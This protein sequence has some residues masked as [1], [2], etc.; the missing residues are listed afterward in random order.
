MNGLIGITTAVAVLLCVGVDQGANLVQ[1]VPLIL[2]R[3]GARKNRPDG[4]QKLS[5][6]RKIAAACRDFILELKPGSKTN[7]IFGGDVEDCTF[8][9]SGNKL[10]LACKGDSTPTI[11]TIHEDGS[12]TGPPGAFMPILRHEK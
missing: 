5:G 11:F 2:F 3:I 10:S 1:F 4:F 7:F 6:L 12:L 8:S 9:T